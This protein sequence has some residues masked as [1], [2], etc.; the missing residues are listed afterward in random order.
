MALPISF[1]SIFYYPG[2]TY[3][4]TGAIQRYFNRYS[5][6]GSIPQQQEPVYHPDIDTQSYGYS[7]AVPRRAYISGGW[8]S[9]IHSGSRCT[10]ALSFTSRKDESTGIRGCINRVLSWDYKQ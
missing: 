9:S 7:Y 2:A 6:G 10:Y 8:S 4:A 5:G 3:D 1:L